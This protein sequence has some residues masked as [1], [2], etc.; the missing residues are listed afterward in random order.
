MYKRNLTILLCSLILISGCSSIAANS[1]ASNG[2]ASRT[3]SLKAIISGQNLS[4]ELLAFIDDF[5]NLTPELQKKAF[6]ETTQVLA[7]NRNNLLHRLKLASMYALP[8]SRMRDNAKAQ[9]LLQ[10]ILQEN[11]LSST[12]SALISLLYEYTTD[13]AKL[14]QKGREDSKK[15]E[16]LQQKYE[17]MELKNKALEQKLNELK[18]IEKTMIER[19]TRTGK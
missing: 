8:T 13:Y 7:Q 11:M 12:D 1:P 18:N 4:A 10:E 15:I 16:S 19:D 9:S 2:K 14:S 17:S 5:S 6:A 3:S